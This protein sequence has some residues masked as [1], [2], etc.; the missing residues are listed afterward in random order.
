MDTIRREA[1]NTMHEARR[2]TSQAFFMEA[3]TP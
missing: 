2:S 3:E 1:A